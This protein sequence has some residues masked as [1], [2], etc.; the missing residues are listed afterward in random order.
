MSYLLIVLGLVVL[1]FGGDIL[2][3]TFWCKALLE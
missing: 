1:I 3:A 2:V